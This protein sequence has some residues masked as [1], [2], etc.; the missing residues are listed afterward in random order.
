M[1]CK[2]KKILI[3]TTGGTIASAKTADGLKPKYDGNALIG[4][5]DGVNADILDL[6]AVDSTDITPKHWLALCRSVKDAEPY[7]GIVVLHG[8]D[9]L[10]YTAA[11]LSQTCFNLNKPVIVTGSMLPFGVKDSDAEKNISD[12]VRAACDERLNGVY[13]VFAGRIIAGYDAVKRDSLNPDS[14]QS[15]SGKDIGFIREN[16]LFIENIPKAP[17]QYP[18][19]ETADAKIAVIKLSPFIDEFIVPKEFSGA[20]IE[21][22][23]AGGMPDN[24][25]LLTSLK[26]LCKRM[27][28]IMTTGCTS[29]ANLKTYEV[30]KR[31]L[32]CGVIDGGE[33][34][35]AFAAV[36]LFLM[37]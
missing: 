14:F 15:F 27:P 21:S 37:S 7:D 17:R 24:E 11:A 4:D 33:M 18:I 29:G 32:D 35:T 19:P 36:K 34:S 6:F 26:A 31:A 3:I 12:S 9:T 16:R 20:V 1:D 22:Y 10:E 5:I 23:G 30:G 28:I 8:T 2:K 13:V 25:Q